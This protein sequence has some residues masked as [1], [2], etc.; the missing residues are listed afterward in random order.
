[1]PG[2][3]RYITG[4]N[5][6]R[7]RVVTGNGRGNFYNSTPTTTT[8]STTTT[9]T[10]GVQVWYT[11]ERCNDLVINYSIN[12][13]TGTFNIND[14]VSYGTGGSILYFRVTATN[15]SNP[16]G[17]QWAVSATGLGSCPTTTTTTTTTTLAPIT[18]TATPS[19]NGSTAQ[20]VVNNFAG[21][22]GTY[23]WIA[24]GSSEPNVMNAVNGVGGTRF[25]L[26]GLTSYTFTNLAVNTNFYIAMSD[27]NG[28]DS[29][30]VLVTT[31]T[32][33]T[34]TSTTTTTTTLANYEYGVVFCS[35]SGTGT[36]VSNIPL[37]R[38]N[39]Y[40]H[41]SFGCFQ[42]ATNQTVV[43]LPGYNFTS[44]ADCN[45]TECIL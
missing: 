20:I 2:R 19:C 30:P 45:A 34:T 38:F 31:P 41:P 42:V 24:S 16:G 15:S 43:N 11:L 33:C 17:T 13:N 4:N 21:G 27:S 36:V 9:T 26:T 44:I 10:T 14:I 40:Y 18:F 29:A 23:S 28:T 5:I 37:T 25:S 8:T 7:F 35:D 3:F 32:A 22:T 12:Y 39:Y 1:M 6:S